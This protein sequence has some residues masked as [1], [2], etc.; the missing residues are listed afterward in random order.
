MASQKSFWK[1]EGENLGNCVTQMKSILN[2]MVKKLNIPLKNKEL[3]EVFKR[4][5][6]SDGNWTDPLGLK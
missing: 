1:I 2:A 3:E 4:V 5:L 6:N